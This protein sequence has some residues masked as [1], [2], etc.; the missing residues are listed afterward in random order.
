MKPKGLG[1]TEAV[2]LACGYVDCHRGRM[3]YSNSTDLLKGHTIGL[4]TLLY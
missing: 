3:V 4:R 2:R 1:E